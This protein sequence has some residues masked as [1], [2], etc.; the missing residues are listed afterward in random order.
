M[1]WDDMAIHRG[2]R[3]LYKHRKIDKKLF[4]KYKRRYS[5]Y[6]TVASLYLWTIAGGACGLKDY[7]PMTDAKKKEI[8]KDKVKEKKK[9]LHKR[10]KPNH[11]AME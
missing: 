11:E 3:M 2:L 6:A 10:K 9:K 1:S 7:A 4:Q 8:R 5:P